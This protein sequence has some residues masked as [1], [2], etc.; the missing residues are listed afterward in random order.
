MYLSFGKVKTLHKSTCMRKPVPPDLSTL[1]LLIYNFF[2]PTLSEQ[3]QSMSQSITNIYV[4][5]EGE[6]E[7]EG[8][9]ERE[10]RRM[11]GREREREM[12]GWVG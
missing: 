2:F 7:R 10:S 3:K 6:R 9:S 1:Y 12:D 5:R 4:Q 11:G 8:G